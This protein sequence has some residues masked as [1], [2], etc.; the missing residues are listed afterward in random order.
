MSSK[1]R[2][3]PGHI[4]AALLILA[5]AVM[6]RSVNDWGTLS[7][8]FGNLIS[9]FHESLWPADWSVLEPRGWPECT[10]PDALD[11]TCSTAWIGMVETLQIAFVSTILAMTISLPMALLAARNIGTFGTSVIIRLILAAFRSLPSLIWAIFFVILIGLG[12]ISG[13]FAMTI[14]SVGYLGKLQYEA[15]EGMNSLPLEAADAAGLSRFEKAIHVAIPESANDLISQAIF[16]FEY[17]VR[18]GSIIGIVGAGGI[19]YYI[20]RSLHFL[21]YDEVLAYLIIIFVV[22][23]VIDF[24]SAYARSFFNDDRTAVKRSSWKAFFTGNE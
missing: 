17:N 10:A 16:M 22:V 8:G 1:L 24:I 7:N 11:F 20:D 2:I 9:F 13:I 19:G 15:I 18:H 12:T 6:D 3:Y 4:F 14:Y 23:I 5:L 21:A